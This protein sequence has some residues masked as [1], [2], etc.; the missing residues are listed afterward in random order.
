MPKRRQVCRIIAVPKKRK[1]EFSPDEHIASRT[2]ELIY[3]NS[4]TIRCPI[5]RARALAEANLLIAKF[6]E[7]EKLENERKEKKESRK[8]RS[9]DVDPGSN[10]KR[11]PSS[12]SASGSDL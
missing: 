2:T 8:R 5:R 7:E 12:A 4:M 11:S 9:M 3:Y 6:R 1:M 10:V